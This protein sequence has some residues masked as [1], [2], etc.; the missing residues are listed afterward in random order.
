[1]VFNQVELMS[2]KA[3]I[4][5]QWRYLGVC[6]S[7][8]GQELAPGA[9]RSAARTYIQ[10]RR[11]HRTIVFFGPNILP[12]APL[13]AHPPHSLVSG[14]AF[15]GPRLTS[16]PWPCSLQTQPARPTF[17]GSSNT[18]LQGWDLTVVHH[19]FSNSSYGS[20]TCRHQ[21]RL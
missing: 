19:Q 5:S 7:L 14:W 8:L 21:K 9:V 20:A 10:K 18:Q 3:E 1:M 6:S 11:A 13:T 16:L 2:T 15:A 17:T 4:T 12:K